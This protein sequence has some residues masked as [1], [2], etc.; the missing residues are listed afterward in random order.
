MYFSVS[1]CLLAIHHNILF[2][3]Y[4]HYTVFLANLCIDVMTVYNL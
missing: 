3:G 4:D 1:F 2:N